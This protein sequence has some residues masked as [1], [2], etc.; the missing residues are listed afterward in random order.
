MVGE[1][2]IGWME[3]LVDKELVGWSQSKSC[4]QLVEV[5]SNDVWHS[6]GVL[7]LALFNICAIDIVSGIE[8][9]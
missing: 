2:W 8:S 4:G 3:Y 9:P 5:E 1:T 6:L 7:R